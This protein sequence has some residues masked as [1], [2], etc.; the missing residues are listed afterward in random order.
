MKHTP[1]PWG[2]EDKDNLHM[3]TAGKDRKGRFVYVCDPSYSPRG[4]ER[5]N[6]K[7]IA[8]APELL[9]ALRRLLLVSR[10]QNGCKK[11]DM[12]CATRRA[13]D[14]LKKFGRKV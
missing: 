1:G 8:A 7:L 2:F 6:A 3:V 11:T 13:E 5:A 14:V 4:A 12:S 10:C 9:A